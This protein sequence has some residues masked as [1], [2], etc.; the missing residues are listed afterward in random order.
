MCPTLYLFP[1]P[2]HV[3]WLSL[4]TPMCVTWFIWRE[5]N[6]R[7][8]HVVGEWISHL[9]LVNWSVSTLSPISHLVAAWLFLVFVLRTLYR[10]F[11]RFRWHPLFVSKGGLLLSLGIFSEMQC[12]FLFLSTSGISCNPFP[13]ILYDHPY[14]C[15]QTW[16][17]SYRIQPR[18]NKSQEE[19][20]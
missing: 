18:P 8:F 12:L 19:L 20:T 1:H 17:V 10:L 14:L 2:I 4:L 3:T 6:T 7:S 9:F 13:L 16:I 11:D 5:Q 15:Q